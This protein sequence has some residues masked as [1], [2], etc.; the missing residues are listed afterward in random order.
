[1]I[2][3]GLPPPIMVLVVYSPLFFQLSP[4]LTQIVWILL[5]PR[6]YCIFPNK[7]GFARGHNINQDCF[8]LTL[9]CFNGLDKTR[10]G[11]NVALKVNIRKEF[12]TMKRNFLAKFIQ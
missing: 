7:F 12:D 10:F 9:D 1:M 11:S 6:I 8:A 2:Y 5:A 3:L 4:K